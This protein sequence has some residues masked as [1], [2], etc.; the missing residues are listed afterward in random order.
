MDASNVMESVLLIIMILASIVAYYKIV[1]LEVRKDKGCIIRSTRTSSSNY[2]SDV[3]ADY[4]S[5]VNASDA[6]GTLSACPLP[7]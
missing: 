4:V 3:N 2:V 5:D 1:G 6:N 7:Y